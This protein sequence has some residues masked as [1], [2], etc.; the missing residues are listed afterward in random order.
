MLLFLS[1]LLISSNVIDL[2]I[3]DIQIINNNS[4]YKLVMAKQYRG[5]KVFNY[6]KDVDEN[7]KINGFNTY[8]LLINSNFNDNLIIDNYTYCNYEVEDFYSTKNIVFDKNSIYCKTGKLN[9]SFSLSFNISNNNI[10]YEIITETTF[11]DYKDNLLIFNESFP[12]ELYASS[13]YAQRFKTYQ[14]GTKTFYVF[15]LN[16][17]N[18]AVIDYF[19]KNNIMYINKNQTEGAYLVYL[20]KDIINNVNNEL[21][22]MLSL[23]EI[24][25]LNEF[26]FDSIS[27]C[28]ISDPSFKITFRRKI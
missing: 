3:T 14:H 1:C 6:I 15:D 12:S 24:I 28:N 17:N 27:N 16:F 25:E 19:S 26:S 4:S 7:T 18:Y 13:S 20:K 8:I 21:I 22:C 2:S 23:R 11:K 9:T 10:F 5:S